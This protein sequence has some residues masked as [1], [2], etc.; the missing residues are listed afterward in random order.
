MAALLSTLIIDDEAPAR[1]LVRQYLAEFP[2]FAVVGE[3]ADGLS[4]LAA[5]R[6]QA[7][8][9]LFLDIQMPGLTGFDVLARLD[10][11]PAVVICTAYDQYA[12]GPSTRARSTTCLSP[13]TVSGLGRRL[14][15]CWPAPPH[16]LPM[17][18]C[19]GCCI[20]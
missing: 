17:R 13:T 10:Q 11:V 18:V 15:A 7:P 2:A 16:L 9:V 14:R 3:C 6:K 1:L 5:I 4:A 20:T 19:S 12:L 8:D